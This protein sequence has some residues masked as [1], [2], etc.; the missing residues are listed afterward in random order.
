MCENIHENVNGFFLTLQTEKY[1][2]NRRVSQVYI[3]TLLAFDSRSIPLK[4]DDN[5]T[6]DRVVI[7]FFL[8]S[9]PMRFT[10]ESSTIF[11]S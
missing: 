3:Y 9:T 10:R 11:A 1:L 2:Y 5:D 6:P 4:K 8:V 7:T